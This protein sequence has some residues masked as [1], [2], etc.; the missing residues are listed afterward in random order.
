MIDTKYFPGIPVAPEN[1]VGQ[2]DNYGFETLAEF[3]G[4]P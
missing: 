4:Q 1:L 3:R 2:G